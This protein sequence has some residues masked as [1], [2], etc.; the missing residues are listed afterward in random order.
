MSTFKS[1]MICLTVG[2][3]AVLCGIFL[4]VL[5]CTSGEE[6]STETEEM[7]LVDEG[8][9]PS[10]RVFVPSAQHAAVPIDGFRMRPIGKNFRYNIIGLW[11]LL[12]NNPDATYVAGVVVYFEDGEDVYQAEIE[13][14]WHE[15]R[16]VRFER[17]NSM[18]MYYMGPRKV[19]IGE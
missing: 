19:L 8:D 11:N 3:G 17:G 16:M 6:D 4:G 9:R 7:L 18:G 2:I 12:E 13:T 14:D 5:V 1:W 10:V 15:R